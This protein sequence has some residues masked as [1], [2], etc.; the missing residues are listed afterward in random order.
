[1]RTEPSIKRVQVACVERCGWR[2]RRTVMLDR[3]NCP[4]C[5]QGV[6]ARYAPTPSLNGETWLPVV[7][8]EGIYEVSD[9][10]RVKRVRHTAG[11]HAGRLLS[12]RARQ[13]GYPVVRLSVHNEQ[14]MHRVH[15]MVAEAFLGPPPT[16]RAE[17]HH[18]DHDRENNNVANLEWVTHGENIKA[19]VDAGIF[20]PPRIR[21][22]ECSFSKLTEGDV[23]EIRAAFGTVSLVALGKRYKVSPSTIS[24]IKRGVSWQWMP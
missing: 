16:P 17:V 3:K 24:Q 18:V 15:R 11:T 19:A 4:R 1:M 6:S 14:V 8:Y 13:A 22:E 21:G 9:L 7:G 12:T 20:A 2:G 23:R 5:G 10:G